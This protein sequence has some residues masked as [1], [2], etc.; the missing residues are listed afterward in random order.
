MYD[1]FVAALTCPSCGSVSPADSSTNMQTHVRRNAEG[2]EIPAGYQLDAIDMQDDRI[3][4]AG[5]LSIDGTRAD[6]KI[7]LLEQWECPTCGH[8]NWSRVT[9]DQ[10]M[11]VTIE[12]ITLDRA[13]L[14][15]AQFITEN[16]FLLAARLSGIAANDFMTGS[17]SPVAVLLEHLP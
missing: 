2:M 17:V 1:Y 8:E 10:G 11:I 4:G 7:R 16:C 9:I 14:A 12:S 6:R 13:T 15:T 3:R 5:Y